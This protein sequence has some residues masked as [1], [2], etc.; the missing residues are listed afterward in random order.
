MKI[1]K[2]E[3]WDINELVTIGIFAVVI[4]ISSYLIAL[5]GGGM[6][7]LAFLLK[8]I[9]VVAI[10]FVLMSKIKK[11]GTLTLYAL[12][13]LAVSLLFGRG[14]HSTL[15]M[16]LSGIIADIFMKLIN[17]Y[18]KPWKIGLG[19][20]IYETV[21]RFITMGVAMFTARESSGMMMMAIIAVAIGYVGCLAGIPVGFYFTKELKHAG[22]IRR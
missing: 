14:G 5:A 9:V 4:K 3:Y 2:S 10:T 22:L 7:P 18:Q 11:Y 21:S 15:G 19:I 8:N 1:F 16:V 6:N 17:G 13:V 20:F 12:I